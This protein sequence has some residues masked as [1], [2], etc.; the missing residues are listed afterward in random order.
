MKT[1]GLILLAS[2]LV[3]ICMNKA[4]ASAP[5]QAFSPQD[6]EPLNYASFFEQTESPTDAALFDEQHVMVKTFTDNNLGYQ[7]LDMA[8]SVNSF[9][10]S[11]YWF[12]ALKIVVLLGVL[13]WDDKDKAKS[14]RMRH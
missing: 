6:M 5:N 3:L 9:S 13:M 4:Y 7:T 10:I 11:P 8:S 2:V 12:Y 1:A 14:R